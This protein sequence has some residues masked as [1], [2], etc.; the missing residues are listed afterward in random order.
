MENQTSAVIH[1]LIIEDEDS[2]R[3]LLESRLNRKGYCITATAS[4]EEGLKAA[5]EKSFDVAL[6]DI[7]LPGMDGIQVLQ[8]L[9]QLQSPPEVLMMTGHGTIETAIEA[10]RQG[11]YHYLTKPLDLKELELVLAKALEKRRLA[12]RVEGLNRALDRQTGEPEIVGNSPALLKVID[13]TRKAASWD[14]PVLITGESGT[15]KELIAKALHHWSNRKGKPWIAI[16]CGTLPSNLLESELFGHEKGAFSGAVA[17]RVGLVEAAHEGTLF[18]DEIGELEVGLQAKLLRFLESGE[19]R[20]I[21]NNRLFKSKVRVVAATNKNLEEAIAAG[22]FREDLYYRLS[23]MVL[24]LPPL[25]ERRGDIPL[26]VQYFLKRRYPHR[27]PPIDPSVWERLEA[28]RFPGNVRELAH[29]VD[30]AC[31]LYDGGMLSWHHFVGFCDDGVDRSRS[32][33][34]ADS[35]FVY[36]PGMPLE[37]VRRRHI[38][39]TLAMVGG[40]KA[41][42]AEKLGIGLR[43]LYR[44]LEEWNLAQQDELT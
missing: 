25:R 44:Y 22:Q 19:Y 9:R 6:V 24:R 41:V 3:S 35:A 20:R 17:S 39:A 15:G 16:N 2:F 8:A 27:Q 5:R 43:T 23:G 13:L 26:L 12:D 36:P 4:G 21:G 40:N 11:A 31:M 32:H 7:R 28:Y 38:L 37:E 10:M 42:A 14:I 1:V 34:P 18:L 29:M 30:R 33:K